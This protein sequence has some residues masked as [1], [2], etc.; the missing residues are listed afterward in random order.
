M[1]KYKPTKEDIGTYAKV[2]QYMQ[3]LKQKVNGIFDRISGNQ[4]AMNYGLPGM[5]PAMAGMYGSPNP[6][7]G[8]SQFGSSSDTLGIL[9]GLESLVGKY[10]KPSSKGKD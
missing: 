1:E 7:L 9:E 3:Q 2:G 6:M 8:G 10:L 4:P 5:Q